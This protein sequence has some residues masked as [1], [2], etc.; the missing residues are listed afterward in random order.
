MPCLNGFTVLMTWIC[1]STRKGELT[2][3][4]KVKSG[5][6]TLTTD[7]GSWFSDEPEHSL[8]GVLVKGLL[9]HEAQ[10]RLCQVSRSAWGLMPEPYVPMSS[11]VKYDQHTEINM[12]LAE[13]AKFGDWPDDD[14]PF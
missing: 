1:D 12:L 4:A 8:A 10:H 9:V 5:S 11:P 13:T 2:L 6:K 7:L 14:L 3:K